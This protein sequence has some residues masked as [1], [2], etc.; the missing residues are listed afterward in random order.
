MNAAKPSY[1]KWVDQLVCSKVLCPTLTVVPKANSS[2]IEWTG[3]H[4]WPVA[5]RIVTR[6]ANRQLFGEKLAENAEFLQLS[7]DYTYTVFDGAHAIRGYPSFLRPLILR[8]KTSV[9]EQRALAKKHLVPLFQ[10]RICSMQNATKTGS[11][12]DYEREKPNDAG[13]TSVR[14]LMLIW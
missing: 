11:M 8:W 5:C 2:H 7:I 4:T 14:C 9:A 13:T 12:A 1:T 6:T 10:D 3:K